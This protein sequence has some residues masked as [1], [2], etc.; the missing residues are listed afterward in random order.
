M[1]VR[2][3]LIVAVALQTIALIA[4]VGV[5]QWTLAT[6][7]PVLLETQPVDPRSLFRGDYVILRYAINR[8]DAGLPGM[9]GVFKPGETLY[10]TLREDA[11]FWKP[12]SV[13]SA[14]P[15]PQPGAV[16]IKGEIRYDARGVKAVEMRYGIEEYFV[17]E[18]EGREIERPRRDGKVSILVA[19]DRFGNAGIKAVL[20]DGVTRYEE[21]LF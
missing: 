13:H 2:L 10:V 16:V 8:L 6:G 20:I 14:R 19:V 18:G 5:K 1:S 21:K 11:P 12:V 3:G 9:P 17:P 7:T 15:E 4:I